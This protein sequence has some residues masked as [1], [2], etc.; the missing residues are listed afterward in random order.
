MVNGL[1][2]WF[3]KRRGYGIIIPD[4]HQEVFFNYKGILEDKNNFKILNEGD[5][6]E[7]EVFED[8][9]NRKAINIK[10]V[11]KGKNNE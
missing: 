10:S 6:V 3:N 8:K 9:W 1:V 5:K 7:F 4:K 2:K 11:E